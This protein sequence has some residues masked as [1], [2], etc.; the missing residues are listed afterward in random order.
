MGGAGR[1]AAPVARKLEEASP[2]YLL[3]RELDRGIAETQFT[4]AD[5]VAR[6]LLDVQSYDA[7]IISPTRTANL[8]VATDAIK[9]ATNVQDAADAAS[10]LAGSVDELL[11][12]NAAVTPLPVEPALT[13]APLPTAGGRVEPILTGAELPA[14]GRV[15]PVLTTTTL[16]SVE[17][18]QRFG[19]DKLR[20]SPPRPQRIQ[21]EPV[22]NLTDDQLTAISQDESVPAITRRS[23]AVELTA[24][25]A[26]QAPQG[27][28]IEAPARAEPIQTQQAAPTPAIEA[29]TYTPT[30]LGQ[31]RLGDRRTL[32]RDF[33]QTENEDGSITFTR[34]AAVA[35]ETAAGP[36]P[37]A[38]AFVTIPDTT[39]GAAAVSDAAAP[40]VAGL[41]DANRARATAQTTL[42]QWA[43]SNGVTAPRLNT[44]A[45]DQD[46]AVNDIANALKK[47][48]RS[49]F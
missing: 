1:V 46:A 40:T 45:A 16:P 14:A 4:Q 12:P 9:Q 49:G 47:E 24:R 39:P 5:A 10:V 31:M 30:E 32:A 42:D 13:S 43:A 23:A 6:R 15:E 20:L 37:V 35:P 44:P 33:D 29:R 34:R 7:N 18:E 19:L 41:P 48:N 22:A 3:S 36:T 28:A 21:G 17:T 27:A 25:Q 11:V 26:E 8:Q 2:A 38:G